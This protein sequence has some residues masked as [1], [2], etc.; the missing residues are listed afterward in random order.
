MEV[1]GA[2]VVR[3]FLTGSPQFKVVLND[4]LAV[5]DPSHKGNIMLVYNKLFQNINTCSVYQEFAM[6]E[7]QTR[8]LCLKLK[9]IKYISLFIKYTCNKRFLVGTCLYIELNF[10]QNRFSK[11]KDYYLRNKNYSPIEKRCY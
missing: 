11:L 1:N 9:P 3:N 5:V 7:L 8:C 10:K 2:V 4:D 6:S